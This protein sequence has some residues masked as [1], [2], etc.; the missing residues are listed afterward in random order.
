MTIHIVTDSTADIPVKIINEYGIQVVPLNIHFGEE[1]LKDGVD[2]W[3]EEF[4]NRLRN[5]D[6][7]PNTS[8][9]APGEFLTIYQRIAKPGDTI[10][11]I[12]I[13]KEMSG[14]V[15]SAEIAASMLPEEVTVRVIDS[16]NVTLGLGTMVIK[17]AQLAQNGASVTAIIEAIEKW[18]EQ[19]GVYFTVNSLE[20]LHRT[21]RIG[22]ASALLGGLLNIKPVLAIEDGIIIPVEKVRG[23]F[24][25]VAAQIVENI[26]QRYGSAP[27]QVCYLHTDLPELN[28]CLQKAAEARLN[29]GES[30][31]NLVGPIVGAHGGPFTIGIAVLPLA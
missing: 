10:I 1:V 5:E 14:T 3:S 26:Y 15:G 20:Y 2:I 18:K 12:H 29:I 19:V 24:A 25:K 22:K 4:Y 11:S 21:G 8:Q 28:S 23:Q 7:L 13:S 9:P 6:L 16:R 17:A 27:L 31:T 30:M